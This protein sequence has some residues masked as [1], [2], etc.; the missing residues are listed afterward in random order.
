[1]PRRPVELQVLS[2]FRSQV[3]RPWLRRVVTKALEAV[4]PGGAAGVSV[5]IA[6]DATLHTL[7]RRYRGVDEPTDVL[8][9]AWG[10]VAGGVDGGS[11]HGPPPQ[12]SFPP[13]P[14]GEESLGEVL[15]S[16]PWAV[17]QAQAHGYP[18]EREVAWLV[19]HGVLH[20]L[21]HDHAEPEEAAAM[22]K[23]EDH[24]LARA[25]SGSQPR[26]EG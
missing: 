26:S 7:N 11:S 5:V 22:R 2:P 23:L 9:F 20:L 8:A 19:V 17:R 3:M 4:D 1:M 14:A 24:T 13:F 6:D 15:V 16:Y 18:V 12:V 10:D 25:L 21:G